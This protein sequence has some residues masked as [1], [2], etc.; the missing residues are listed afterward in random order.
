MNDQPMSTESPANPTPSPVPKPNST[1]SE[2]YAAAQPRAR[3]MVG[4]FRSPRD[5][6]SVLNGALLRIK[7][8]KTRDGESWEELARVSRGEFFGYLQTA[9]HSEILDDFRR[10][11]RDL[12]V[13]VDDEEWERIAV[14]PVAPELAALADGTTRTAV[15][16]ELARLFHDTEDF[17]LVMRHFQSE[18]SVKSQARRDGVKPN[19][20]SKE[21]CRA[22]AKLRIRCQAI[23]RRLERKPGS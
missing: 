3:A 1:L 13:T 16:D 9:L 12:S 4:K 20:R 21:L 17:Q 6:D 7:K 19:T 14:S 10:R 5:P 15:I 23:Q 11:G 18:R 8:A 2:R 22:L